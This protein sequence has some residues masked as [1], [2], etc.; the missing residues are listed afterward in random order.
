MMGQPNKPDLSEKWQI[1]LE[2][3]RRSQARTDTRGMTRP[4]RD[5]DEREFLKRAGQQGPFVEAGEGPPT[6]G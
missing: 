3:I 1:R 5:P 4:P 6:N 2:R